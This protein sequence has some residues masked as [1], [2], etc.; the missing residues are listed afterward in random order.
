MNDHTR[1]DSGTGTRLDPSNAD[2]LTRI[3]RQDIPISLSGYATIPSALAISYLMLEPITTQGAEADL[4]II[5][6]RKNEHKY[7]LKLYRRG[8]KPKS[9]VID[10]LRACSRDHVI[11]ILEWGES[12]GLWY[13]ILEYGKY[14]TLRDM[15]KKGP[16]KHDQMLG[17]V[18]DLLNS[19]EHIHSRKIIHRDLKPENILI[20]SLAPL[21]L[22]LAD[23]GIASLSDAT[24]HFTTKS[25]TIKYGAPEAA[26]GAVGTASDFWSLGLII[27]EGLTGRHP[28]DDLSDLSIAV[29][30]ATRGVDVD[31]VKN[32]RWKG[33]CKGLLTRDPKERWSLNQVR[34]WLEGGMP[35]VPADE[36]ERPSQ[37]P[38]KI[39]KRECWTAAELALEFGRN[40]SEAEKHLA[41]NLVLPWLRDELRDQD[42][43]N[44]LIDLAENRS[45]SVEGRLLRLVAHFGRGLPPVWRGLSLDQATLISLCREAAKGDPEKAELILTLFDEGILDVWGDSGN[46]DCAE[47]SKQWKSS[48]KYFSARV[49]QISEATGLKNTLPDQKTY[50]PSI[51]LV[52]LSPE[53]RQ[54]TR[55]EVLGFAEQA[56]RCAWLT[57]TLRDESFTALLVLNLFRNEA[58]SLGNQEIRAADSLSAALE[59]IELE[60]AELLDVESQ[61][62]REVQFARKAITENQALKYSIDELPELKRRLFDAV[63]SRTVVK[64]FKTIRSKLIVEIIANAIFVASIFVALRIW[65]GSEIADDGFG[66][67]TARLSAKVDSDAEVKTFLFVGLA[68]VTLIW[69][70]LRSSSRRLAKKLFGK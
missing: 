38:Y 5:E 66:S 24:Q 55:D 54:A 49:K 15:F 61:F 68:V 51:L 8:L 48:A 50:L 52:I 69:I 29:Q 10:I 12:D 47:W 58:V 21:D 4:F 39:A 19:I 17:I 43:S 53:F 41:R 2:G 14:G 7:V 56:S 37:R 31:Q 18:R 70:G 9:D 42:A 60:Y 33:L 11:E 45:I 23:F 40:W 67:I 1:I 27:F 25:R 63:R 32:A 6:S 65:L 64:S 36:I 62:S 28:F 34:E 16:V 30:L 3:D 57:D 20:R 13:E 59:Q 44:F 22:M 26:A 46:E 35:D